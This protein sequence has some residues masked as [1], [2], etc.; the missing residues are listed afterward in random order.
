MI[1]GEGWRHVVLIGYRG[2]GKTT[3]GRRLAARLNVPHVDTD[4]LVEADAR[5]T[6][7]EVFAIEGERGFRG[8]ES[9][10]VARAAE[11]GSSVISLGGGAVLNESDMRRLSGA[12]RIVH[13]FASADVLAGRIEGDSATGRSRPSLTGRGTVA[14]TGALAAARDPAYRRWADLVVETDAMGP[15]RIAEI[16][17]TWLRRGV[18]GS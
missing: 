18:P 7:A 16:I 17:E 10:A 5:K 3:V 6:I 4:A 15:D 8:R 9:A 11:G 13:L 14:E 1:A 2:S 12:S